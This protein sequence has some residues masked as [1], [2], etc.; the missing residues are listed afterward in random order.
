MTGDSVMVF[1]ESAI[2]DPTEL[3][4]RFDVRATPDNILDTGGPG[5][6]VHRKD[7]DNTPP[8]A[9]A[10]GGGYIIPPSTEDVTGK[11]HWDKALDLPS[12]PPG[13]NCAAEIVIGATIL[14][15]DHCTSD[16]DICWQRTSSCT[17]ELGTYQS[18][19]ETTEH[20]LGTQVGS[21]YG[22]VVVNRVRTKHPGATLK[23]EILKS[24]VDFPATV[25]DYY[26]GVRVSYCTGISQRV[27]MT[28]LVGDLLPVF[29]TTLTSANH[30]RTWQ[31]LKS[32]HSVVDIF[33]GSESSW[34]DPQSIRNWL[35]QLEA[36]QHDYIIRLIRL[37]VRTLA[38]TGLSPNGSFFAVAWP[39]DNQMKN[40]LRV[41]FGEDDDT[42]WIPMLADSEDCATFA[43]ITNACLPV[44]GM[45]ACR[46]PN[47]M[48]V[49]K[50]HLLETAVSFPATRVMKSLCHGQKYFFL[51]DGDDPAW[52]RAMV[53][54]G[55]QQTAL[56]RLGTFQSIP[57]GVRRR[58]TMLE[59]RKK[60]EGRI[61][62]K[63]LATHLAE[64]VR[65]YSRLPS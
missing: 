30:R 59:R 8:V 47:P 56:V 27:P 42:K 40:C 32:T 14:V 60:N 1:R 57:Q 64:G 65:I 36:D 39:R 6:L 3:T 13:L 19:Y 44:E 41:Q 52:F 28:Q 49:R 9:I 58:M 61:Q 23:D 63:R 20:Q 46:G 45:V 38:A 4:E 16:D 10:I 48:W 34:A 5:G 18:Y 26:S 31:E 24:L 37:I 7:S 25:L 11:Y 33:K 29:A 50:V 53:V 15:N 55:E 21:D 2:S 17:A 62:E 35:G 22:M 51:K 43:Y 54:D 12:S